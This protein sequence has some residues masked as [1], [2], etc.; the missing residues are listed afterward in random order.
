MKQFKNK[1]FNISYFKIIVVFFYFS[2]N[3]LAYEIPAKYRALFFNDQGNVSQTN[4]VV[5]NEASHFKGY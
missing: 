4:K 1:D 5:C 3:L 2:S